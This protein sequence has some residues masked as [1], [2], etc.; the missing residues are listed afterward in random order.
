[1]KTKIIDCQTAMRIKPALKLTMQ[2]I[3]KIMENPEEFLEHEYWTIPDKC[4]IPDISE[5]LDRLIHSLSPQEE[6]N[7]HA[8]LKVWLNNHGW[9][10]SDNHDKIY[11]FTPATDT[12]PA[13]TG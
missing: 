9:D 4:P 13:T 7:L 12:S 1:M 6:A 5:N 8:W 3:S 10:I 11:P 2:T